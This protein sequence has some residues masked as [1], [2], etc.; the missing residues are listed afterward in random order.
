MVWIRW[1]C[2]SLWEMLRFYEMQVGN[3]WTL[4]WEEAMSFLLYTLHL[5]CCSVA[6]PHT[7]LMTPVLFFQW[8]LLVL[9]FI[10]N[11][12]WP[13]GLKSLSCC[14]AALFQDSSYKPQTVSPRSVPLHFSCLSLVPSWCQASCWLA[15]RG[16][17][18]SRRSGPF[19]NNAPWHGPRGGFFYKWLL[20]WD[21]DEIS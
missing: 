6:M 2:S 15:Q 1:L 14:L 5:V 17:P 3:R 20:H 12:D 8:L 18:G 10:K 9:C 4:S 19:S 11:K 7:C 21:H 13:R 16:I